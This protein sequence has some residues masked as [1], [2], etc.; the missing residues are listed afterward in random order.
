MGEL[1]NVSPLFAIAIRSNDWTWIPN[2]FRSYNDFV[3]WAVSRPRIGKGMQVRFQFGKMEEYVLLFKTMA[4][5]FQNSTIVVDEADALYSVSKFEE[6]LNNL[7]LG[8]RNNNLNLHYMSKRPFLIPVLVRSQ[9]DRF[10]VFCTEEKRDIEYL[11]G[12]VRTIFP[13]DPFK[14][15]VGEAIVLVKQGQEWNP[16]IQRFPKF[17]SNQISTTR[18]GEGVLPT[19]RRLIRLTA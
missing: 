10:V 5:S 4:E 12:R 18:P 13:K 1:R 9:A 7:F 6:P 15:A 2:T 19:G 17:N 11:V 3:Y 8:S 14:L 16:K